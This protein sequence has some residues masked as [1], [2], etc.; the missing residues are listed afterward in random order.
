MTVRRRHVTVMQLPERLGMEERRSFL[1]DVEDS[2]TMERPYLVVDCSNIRQLDK[3]AVHLLLCCLEE[4]L[5][6]NGD[7]KLA[8]IPLITEVMPGFTGASRLF[9][10]YDTTADAVNSFRQLPFDAVTERDESE[11]A[12]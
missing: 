6:R 7:V 8:G 10:I 12:A 2:M 3:S 1:R 9:E 4:A 5:K 11:S